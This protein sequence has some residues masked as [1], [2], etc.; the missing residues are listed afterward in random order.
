MGKCY[1]CQTEITLKD[2]ETRCD[3][4]GEVVN[5][6]CWNCKK[7]FGVDEVK[8]CKVCGFYVCPDCG[9]CYSHCEKNVWCKEIKSILL[10]EVNHESTPNI[11][12]KLKQILNYIE[13]IKT[14]KERKWCPNNVPI[15]YAK[16]RIKGCLARM[17]GFAKKSE[18]DTQKFKDRFDKLLGKPINYYF[19][20]TKIREEGSY[21]QEYR[22]V[23]NLLVCLG[24]L[25]LTKEIR[26]DKSV[27]WLYT[28]IEE[29]PCDN[30]LKGNIVVARCQKCK[31][32]YSKENLVCSHC[33]PYTKGKDKGKQRRLNITT[34][35]KDVCQL[36]RG[37]FMR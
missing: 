17:E 24:K 6:C 35:N 28:R 29:K 10:P 2:E 36:N 23:A 37:E 27:Y 32:C 30:I 9:L 8:E 7:W 19:T 21:G 5:Y 34:T 1:N 26:K 31:R 20:I 22:D 13:S 4:C 25:K 3:N 16:N 12:D 11:S 15:T 18:E 33:K 14:N